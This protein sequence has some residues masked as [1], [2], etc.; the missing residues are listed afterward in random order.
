MEEI[1]FRDLALDE[2]ECIKDMNP[3]QYIMMSANVAKSW[4]A[5]K[6]HLCAGSAEETIAFYHAMGCSEALEINQALFEADQRDLQ[7]EYVIQ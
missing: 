6:I 5:D 4:Q 7:L 1:Q 2:C 3:S